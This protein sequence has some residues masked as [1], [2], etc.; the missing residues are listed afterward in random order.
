MGKPTSNRLLYFFVAVGAIV[1][2]VL[3]VA[4]WSFFRTESGGRFWSSMTVAMQQAYDPAVQELRRLGCEGPLVTT[5]GAMDPVQATR[6]PAEERERL[7]RSAGYDTPMVLCANFLG[8]AP[9]CEDVAAAQA[10]FRSREERMAVFVITR[11]ARNCEGVYAASG[12]R[13]GDITRE[14]F[15][16]ASEPDGPAA[17]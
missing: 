3:A 12:E 8:D 16:G 17:Y 15:F 11:G 4:A 1:P 10:P 13:L 6:L 5:V 2:A 9:S 7:V 14:T